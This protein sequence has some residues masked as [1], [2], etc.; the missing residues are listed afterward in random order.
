MNEQQN[1][2]LAGTSTPLQQLIERIKPL[3]VLLAQNSYIKDT[4]KR[5]ERIIEDASSQAMILV[6]G[7]ERVGKTTVINGLLGREVLSASSKNPTSANTFIRY[8]EE[9]CVK[10]VFLDGMVATF[11]IDKVELLTTSDAFCAQIIREHLD[12]IE[13]FIK[14]DLLKTVTIVDSVAL[15]LTT[16]YAAF[17]SEL[18]VN[19]VDEI[20]WVIRSGSVATD[21]ELK[22][23][24]RYNERGVKPHFIINAIDSYEGN[25]VEFVK[26]EYSR[27]GNQIESMVA[28]SATKALEASKTNNEQLK[29]DSQYYE[30]FQLITKLSKNHE[31]KTRH[32]IEQFIEWLNRFKREVEQIPSKEPY[33]SSR[34]NIEKYNSGGGF[35]YTR[36]QR[37]MAILTAYEEEYEHV[38][39]IFKP[40]QTLYQLLQLLTSEL[41]LR[42][43]R[44]ELFED[45]AL[46]YQQAVRDYRK[47]HVEYMQQ[48]GLLD[49]Q[50]RK[51]HGRGIEKGNFGENRQNTVLNQKVIRLNSLQQK[52]KEKLQQ[53]HYFEALVLEH[54][55]ST[56]NYITE[57]ASKRLQ[58]IIH[59]VAELNV[60][61]KREVVVLKSY[62]NKLSEFTCIEDAQSFVRDGILPLLLS[63]TL[64]LSNEHK[65]NIEETIDAICAVDLSQEGLYNNLPTNAYDKNIVLQ[66]DFETKYTL[67]PLSLTDGDILSQVPDL[68]EELVLQYG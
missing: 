58:N 68:P 52:C 66:T 67:S 30:L 26:S 42:D 48:Y 6:M 59:Q 3:Q 17:L 21:S 10:A 27:Y 14:H 57:L 60:Q 31:K 8:G 34:Q 63:G 5:L 44:V 16:E 15:E 4:T 41:Y 35:E 7:K 39:H 47:L 22:L 56:Q 28:V 19:R 51:V 64:A 33:L 55:Y 1:S 54:L 25:I 32:I 18:L 40:I 49:Q 23:L 2:L 9:E 37:D 12:Y 50:L 45:Y 20:F 43:E 36:E 62:V 38:C 61:R 11:D 46:N 65:K 29:I 53:I 13:V 24:E